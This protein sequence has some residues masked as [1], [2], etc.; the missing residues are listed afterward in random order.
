VPVLA[1]DVGG[2]A[3]AL[4]Y[5]DDGI[6]PGLLVPPRDPEALGAALRAWLEDAELR[7]RLRRAARQ[8]RTTLRPWADTASAIAGVLAEVAARAEEAAGVAEHA[9]GVANVAGVAR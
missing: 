2:V 9:A 8:R 5:G 1:T 7:E 6:R 4:G 3:E